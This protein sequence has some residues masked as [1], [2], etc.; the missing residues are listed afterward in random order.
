MNPC[1]ADFRDDVATQFRGIGRVLT[2]AGLLWTVIPGKDRV[3]LELTQKGADEAALRIVAAFNDGRACRPGWQDWLQ[4]RMESGDGTVSEELLTLAG[5]EADAQEGPTIDASLPIERRGLNADADIREGRYA[6]GDALHALAKE[7]RG[8]AA[9]GMVR[10]G[11]ALVMLPVP[12]GAA[13]AIAKDRKAGQASG[14]LAVFDAEFEVTGPAPEL[15]GSAFPVRPASRRTP[16]FGEMNERLI[17]EVLE[18]MQQE[19]AK[20]DARFAG[21]G[22]RSSAKAHFIEA[23]EWAMLGVAYATEAK[24]NQVAVSSFIPGDGASW[25]YG[26]V[27]PVLIGGLASLGTSKAGKAAAFALMASWALAMAV[28]TAS[29]KDYLD[30]AQGWFPKGQA[31]LAHEKALAAAKLEAAADEKEVSHLEGKPS[32]NTAALIADARKRWQAAAL[33]ALGVEERERAAVGLASAKAALKQARA[34]VS[35]EEFALREALLQDDSRNWAWRSLFL[36]F[37]VINFAGPF[38]ISRVLEKWRKDHAAAKDE[39]QEDHLLR[40]DA[41]HLRQGRPAQKARAI[42]L[43]AAAMERLE[44]EGIPAD[45]L[46]RLDGAGLAATAADRF[47]RSA[48]AEKFR[49][50]FRLWGPSQT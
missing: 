36:I 25:L 8:L 1:D 23:M 30:G 19:L 21:T 5:L 16:S 44:H 4:L 31:V 3:V 37:G 10:A 33:K 26:L 27:G 46:D 41:K 18:A 13:R 43:L 11:T 29:D 12:D 6:R 40:E 14:A 49:R 24:T 48:N 50:R 22:V 20:K 39:A 32:V 47:D 15:A 38:A 35:G 42:K 17:A 34:R 7:L 2:A 9:G 45:L 28:V